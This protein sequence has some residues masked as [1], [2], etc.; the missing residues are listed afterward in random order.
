MLQVGVMLSVQVGVVD[1]LAPHNALLLTESLMKAVQSSVRKEAPVASVPVP[2]QSSRWRS[3]GYGGYC[4]F[5]LFRTLLLPNQLAA[6]AER[7]DPQS[8]ELQFADVPVAAL[9]AVFLVIVA[10]AANAA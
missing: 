1:E 3:G 5:E 10:V 8:R 9:F 4:S 6:L 7:V 2:I